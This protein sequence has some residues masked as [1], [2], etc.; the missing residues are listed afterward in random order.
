MT[1]LTRENA[2][3]V[4]DYIEI[5]TDSTETSATA[6]KII[7]DNLKGSLISVS[8]A[9]DAVGRSLADPLLTPLKD[10]VDELTFQLRILAED[11]RFLDFSAKLAET[12]S[13]LASGFNSLVS[14]AIESQTALYLL[15][16]IFKLVLGLKMAGW[17]FG[18]VGGMKALTIATT[19]TATA[20]ATAAAAMKVF[21][22]GAAAPG[23]LAAAAATR[24]VSI[25]MQLLTVAV[26][27]VRT[28]MA[29]PVVLVA[30]VLGM[31]K[32]YE[33]Y[34]LHQKS[35]EVQEKLAVTEAVVEDARKQADTRNQQRLVDNEKY[36]E[37]VILSSDAIK[38]LSSVELDAYRKSTAG[39]REYYGGVRLELQNTETALKEQH[40]QQSQRLEELVTLEKTKADSIKSLTDLNLNVNQGLLDS[41]R[42]VQTEINLTRGSMGALSAKI[43]D[44]GAAV[45][46]ASA[47][48]DKFNNGFTNIA[49]TF[50]ILKASFS[51]SSQKIIAESDKITNRLSA[52]ATSVSDFKAAFGGI[53][54]PL[55]KDSDFAGLQSLL[56]ALGNIKDQTSIT[57]TEINEN[58]AVSL[59]KLTGEE[60]A[61]FNANATA[62]MASVGEGFTALGFTAEKSTDLM[63]ASINGALLA[64]GT[65]L[66][67]LKTGMSTTGAETLSILDSL[68]NNSVASAQEITA[69]FQAAITKMDST[70]GL[71]SLRDK[72]IDTF[73]G[74]QISAEEFEN[75]LLSLEVVTLN[76][77]NTLADSY[78]ALG[79]TSQQELNAAAETAKLAYEI[80]RDSGVATTEKLQEAFKAFYDKSVLSNDDLIQSFA[81][82]EIAAQ[83]FATSLN[84][85][86]KDLGLTSQEETDK[87][88]ALAREAYEKIAAS[89]GASDAIVKAAFEAFVGKAALSSDTLTKSFLETEAAAR[90]WK[91]VLK[92]TND[93]LDNTVEKTDDIGDKAS[94]GFDKTTDSVSGMTVMLANAHNELRAFSNAA[95]EL[96]NKNIDFDFGGI[97]PGSFDQYFRTVDRLKQSLVNLAESQSAGVVTVTKDLDNLENVSLTQL[98]TMDRTIDSFNLLDQQTL[99]SVKSQ[100][101]SVRQETNEFH[102]S[103]QD[104]NASL[105]DELDT[106]KGNEAAIAQREAQ[107]DRLELEQSYQEA[108][109]RGDDAAALQAQKNQTLFEKVQRAKEASEKT[110]VVDTYTED[111][112]KAETDKAKAA[113]VARKKQDALLDKLDREQGNKAAITQRKIDRTKEEYDLAITNNE[114]VTAKRA[115]QNISTLEKTLVAELAKEK[116]KSVEDNEKVER[117]LAKE[118]LAARKK[119]D[120]A[121]DK[122]DRARGDNEA[123]I[124]RKIDRLIEERD[125]AKAEEDAT[126]LKRAIANIKIQEKILETEK[127]KT[128]DKQ[129]KDNDKALETKAR[130]ELAAQKKS[131]ALQDKVDKAKGNDEA[132]ILRNIARLKKEQ[133]IATLEQDNAAFNRTVT[134][135]E[136]EY[137]LLEAA[138]DKAAEKALDKAEKDAKKIIDDKARSDLAAQKKSDALQD[139][140]DKDRGNNE[141]V[142]ERRILRLREAADL[143]RAEDDDIALKRA[144]ENIKLEQ[145]L[146]DSEKAKSAKKE[147]DEKDK[148]ITEDAARE[149]TEIQ[150]TRVTQSTVDITIRFEAPATAI[151][152][153]GIDYDKLAREIIVRL[154]NS[155]ALAQ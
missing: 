29:N 102:Q 82:S 47:K 104:V 7:S 87:A 33:L 147:R 24:K 91:D 9:W 14:A 90:G 134:N 152:G 83:G 113:I 140:V 122:L 126:A 71:L 56:L 154:E 75:T 54:E 61:L 30:S 95:V 110:D 155:G 8:S 125:I 68:V 76:T 146:L 149:K 37:T 138:R 69:G 86:Y 51:D 142:I 10:E 26:T 105:Q 74:G 139:K 143:A 77:N 53:V 85:A 63:K 94:Q 118:R 107:Q 133:D 72:L 38:S 81:K 20:T 18:V 117:A 79:V 131:D 96:L 111:A 92:G 27:A 112:T 108:R 145:K 42:A 62:A 144:L 57:A 12:V 31:Q 100:I 109:S 50:E 4:S 16:D 58:L 84:K 35:I 136:Y 127:Q 141:A 44:N 148:A 128:F 137:E 67:T 124:Q 45:A 28:I 3:A 97:A 6:T 78:T 89:S 49:G 106:I 119:E 121:L 59:S 2:N 39:A 73:N 98:D 40:D 55:V 135:I 132:I 11:P 116:D 153:R 129:E 43:T 70:E 101:E 13:S 36:I 93:E 5:V 80:M 25:A 21:V 65:D 115:L 64:L 32:I 66:E 19:A 1:A 99:D 46:D 123:V 22:A 52:S 120:A 150:S 130:A 88:A 41:Q 23:I 17:L 60:F 34:D 48:W 114:A 15:F 103:L 151:D